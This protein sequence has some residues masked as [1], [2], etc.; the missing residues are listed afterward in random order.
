MKKSI[1]FSLLV[2]TI[3]LLDGCSKKSSNN[4]SA[5]STMTATVGG[6]NFTSNTTGAVQGTIGGVNDLTITGMNS[7]I[8]IVID[9]WGYN[10][11]TGSFPINTTMASGTSTASYNPGTTLGTQK[12]AVSGNVTITGISGGA[13]TGTFNFVATDSTNVS[14][15]NFT[16]K[17]L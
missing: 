10:N 17:P 16:V 6:S 13:I 2:A 15:G 11:A 4:T 7:S 12:A 14:N 9:V 8:Q 1:A 5:P 3:I